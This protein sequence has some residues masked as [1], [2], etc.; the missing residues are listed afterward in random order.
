MKIGYGENYYNNNVKV[1]IGVKRIG[2]LQKNRKREGWKKGRMENLRF[3]PS[4]LPTKNLLLFFVGIVFI[5]LATEVESQK[6]NVAAVVSPRH[7]QFSERARLDLTISGET[8][9]KHIEAPQFNFLPAFLAVPLH[10]ETT[11]RLEADKIAV[12]MAWAYELIPQ[13]IGDFALSDI[14][15]AYQG[16]PYFANPGSIRVSGT[17]TYVDI[18]TNAVHQVEAEVD[19]SEPY[20][21]A[22][23]T[24]I[25]RYLY[26]TVLPTRESPTPLLP[27]LSDFRVEEISTPPSQTRQIRGKTFWVEEHVRQL[28]PQKTGQ[29][30]IDPAELVLPLRSGRKTLKTKPLK[31]TVQPLPETGKPQHFSG[32]I[33]KYQ[34]SAQIARSWVE[35]GNA[36]TLSV[37]ISGR[38]N[39]R[40]VTAPK[41]PPIPG[42]I[43][44]G[45]RLT[46]DSTSTSLAYT[47]TLIPSQRGVLRIPA[48]EYTYFDPSR[49]VYATTQTAPI[50]VSVRPNPNDA[51]GDETDSSPWVLWS[52][53]FAILV[54]ILGIGG[55]LWY[56]T[57]FVIPTRGRSNTETGADTPDSRER[58][59]RRTQDTDTEPVTPTSQAREALSALVN[60]DT[61]ENATTFANAL[62]HV[63]YQY[64]EDI[65][66]LSQ[67]NVDTAREV[68]THA[69]ISEPILDEF[70]DLLTQCDYHRFAPV[71]LSVDERNTLIVR[72]EAIVS[73]IEN[74]QDTQDE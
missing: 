40:T 21:N 57:G 72:A 34:I 46:E 64:L 59:N 41:L 14:R 4:N 39:M 54:V 24:Y 60:S 70:I 1:D 48:I 2:K 65:F 30:L 62:A 29:I 49:A 7:I 12:S 18:S 28:Y 45:P 20:L 27:S 43:V 10:S 44:N 8:F 17:D 11:P 22:P 53:L 37:R 74:L 69:G 71:P 5:F 23:L 9:I 42:V 36:L 33:G 32:A 3:Q 73:N 35:A 50:P 31:L 68:C 15:F 61:T 52:V 19:T 38:G 6:I 26:T 55:Y 13:A 63:L 66:E 58:R 51:V 47:Y 16:T 56:R 67:R 25:F